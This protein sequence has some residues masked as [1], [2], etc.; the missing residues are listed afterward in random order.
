MLRDP[1]SD[2][3]QPEWDVMKAQDFRGFIEQ[4]GELRSCPDFFA[5]LI[6]AERRPALAQAVALLI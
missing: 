5:H 1:V 4:L 3:S 2:D 6:L